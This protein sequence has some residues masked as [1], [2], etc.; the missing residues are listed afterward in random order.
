MCGEHESW[1]Q[2]KD[3]KGLKFHAHVSLLH[4]GR[5]GGGSSQH[6]V[7]SMLRGKV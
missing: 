6:M 5:N 4:M 2:S 1:T 7:G 3:Q